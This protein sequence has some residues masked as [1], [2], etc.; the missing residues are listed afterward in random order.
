MEKLAVTLPKK[1]PLAM[2]I[3]AA[4]RQI[5]EWLK[6]ADIALNNERDKLQLTE[7][8]LENRE[9]HYHYSIIKGKASSASQVSNR[10]EGHTLDTSETPDSHCEIEELGA[11]VYPG[12]DPFF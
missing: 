3:S 6:T 8:G 9:Y 1:M 12:S 2:R 7:W 10:R 11:D 5:K 4:S